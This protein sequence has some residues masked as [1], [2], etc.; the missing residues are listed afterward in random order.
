MFRGPGASFDLSGRRMTVDALKR[1]LCRMALMGYNE[2]YHIRRMYLARCRNIRFSPPA[3][4][5][6]RRSALTVK[7]LGIELSP[8]RRP[9]FN[10]SHWESSG[11]CGIHRMCCCWPGTRKPTGQG[12]HA[13]PVPR[14]L[15]HEKY[16]WAWTKP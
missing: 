7:A 13:A 6:R 9:V 15:P 14:M 4:K 2:A 11:L 12:G 10:V 3:G 1:M 8:Y 16:T 5:V